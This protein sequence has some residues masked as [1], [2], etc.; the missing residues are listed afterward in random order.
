MVIKLKNMKKYIAVSDIDPNE[1]VILNAKSPED[2]AF[3][4]LEGLGW[5]IKESNKKEDMDENQYEFS[6]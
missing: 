3:E 4:L 6:F 2:A 1:F 5:S